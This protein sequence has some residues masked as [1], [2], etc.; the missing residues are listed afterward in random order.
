MPSPRSCWA[1]PT[2]GR[3]ILSGSSANSSTISAGIFQDDWRVTDKLV[4][5]L[6]LRWDGNLPPTG[7]NDRWTD[8]SP[9]TPN[10]AAGKI[11]GAVLFAGNCS[12]CVGI[13]NA[14]QFVDE[15]LRPAPRPRLFERL[16]DRDSGRVR[17]LVRIAGFGE[18]LDPQFGFYADADR[19]RAVIR[20]FC[21][22]S[23][24]TAACH[25]G[26][27]LRSSTRRFPTVRA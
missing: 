24:W 14:G 25:H 6:G 3:S 1:M 20:G 10:P 17:A 21:P 12:G 4:V 19:F 23:R 13:A 8:F 11:P 18:R 7:L 22:L 5:N 15:R 16:Q 26:Q 9:T 2:A 27:R